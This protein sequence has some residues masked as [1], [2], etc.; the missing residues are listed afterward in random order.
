MVR[1]YTLGQDTEKVIQLKQQ[2]YFRATL[3]LVL[4]SGLHVQKTLSLSG[5]QGS[6][7]GEL[8]TGLFTGTK[9]PYK[10]EPYLLYLTYL[11]LLIT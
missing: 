9:V 8:N 1:T 7:L 11:L 2:G 6:Y 5:H 10:K 4:S 3:P